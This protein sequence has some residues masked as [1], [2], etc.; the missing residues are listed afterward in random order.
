MA[1]QKITQQLAFKAGGALRSLG[2]LNR[3]LQD[4]NIL[5]KEMQT[6]TGGTAT[7]QFAQN[8]KKTS[9]EI[10]KTKRS[11]AGFTV[12]WETMLR[13]IQTQ[14]I[15]RGL[16]TLMQQLREG[17]DVARQLGINIE[18]IRTIAGGG[19]GG[20]SQI[21]QELIELSNA[22]GKAPTDLAEGLYQTLSNQVVETGE[23]FN[24]M[25]E[26]AKLATVTSSQTG[27]AVNALSSVLNSYNMEASEATHVSGTLFKTVELGR[28]RLGEIANVIGRVTPI[29]ARLGITWEETAASIATMT[30]QGVRA[31]T[32][33]TQLRAVTQKLLKPT[34][35]IKNL[36]KEWGV[37]TGEQAIE[38]FGG[39]VG[40][41]Q[42]MSE[43]TAG[44]SQEMA[45]LFRRVRAIVG[46][47]GIMQDEGSLVAE[48][49][50][51]IEEASNASVK[52]W[53][54][55]SASDAQ[56]YTRTLQEF[57][58]EMT[59]LGRQAIPVITAGLQKINKY[60]KDFAVGWKVVTGSLDAA[61]KIQNTFQKG[62]EELAETIKEID[63][64]FAESQRKQEKQWRETSKAAS[65]Y[66]SYIN[67]QENLASAIRDAGIEQATKVYERSFSGIEDFFSS[68]NKELKK[69]IE[70]AYNTIEG[71]TK[72][73]NDIQ[74]QINQER[75][76]NELSDAESYN[77]KRLILQ[78]ELEA[79]QQRVTATFGEL[80]ADPKTLERAQNEL[81]EVIALTE[82]LE[83]AASASGDTRTVEQARSMRLGALRQQQNVLRQY[84]EEVEKGLGKAKEELKTRKKIAEQSKASMEEIKA[85]IKSGDLTSENEAL[86]ANAEKRLKEAQNTLIEGVADAAAG[87]AILESFNLDYAFSELSSGLEESLN[88]AKKDWDAE[89]DRLQAAFDDKVLKIRAEIDAERVMRDAGSVLG[90]TRISG[91]SEASYLKRV[92]ELAEDTVRTFQDRTNEVD[93]YDARISQLSKNIDSNLAGA[94][95]EALSVLNDEGFTTFGGMRAVA[96]QGALDNKKVV[97]GLS[98]RFKELLGT[99]KN[100]GTVSN[101]ELVKFTG[102]IN[103]LEEQGDIPASFAKNL[104][105]LVVELKRLSKAGEERL[106]ILNPSAEDKEK[107]KAAKIL[108][109][110]R[111]RIADAER[112]TKEQTEST[113]RS[114]DSQKQKAGNVKQELSSAA[115]NAGRV[116][117]QANSSVP[118]INAA[119]QATARWAAQ[120][121]RAAAA[122]GSAQAA[123]AYHGKYFNSGGFARGQDRTLA[124]ISKGEF[125][126]NSKNSKRFFSELNAMNQGSEPV[127]R[128]KG[129]SVTNVGDVN[130]T[131]QGGDT[132]QSTVREIGKSLRR[133]IQRGNIKL[134]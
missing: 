76:D 82:R 113:N 27:D 54:Q 14:I 60:I 89:V 7:N 21:S 85:I 56:E 86:R 111:R 104:R 78:R 53:E 127:Y 62:Q 41:L 50:E 23:A 81:K 10:E 51:Q 29:T 43:S 71:T 79:S 95:K 102:R 25:A 9:K 99:F 103:R 49:L 92:N 87:D 28:L 74:R 72:K 16:S 131:V 98:I 107:L 115:I 2:A 109:D 68:A 55:F 124:A 123:T 35:G 105:T 120:A 112:K 83:K 122:G 106:D 26:A 88:S 110:E 119:A 125:V 100:L 114:L 22:I 40:V 12:T 39:L 129:G 101:E 117:Q 59:V 128:D 18:E 31:D 44:N 13:V 1:P 80:G 17:V 118:G 47:F 30:R 108:L 4:T 96:D 11:T 126:V 5:L 121:E 52:A 66:Y 70:E 48:S 19:L 37:E 134:R 67:R 84:N 65:S 77:Q 91:E 24:F 33:I 58:N 8:L 116:G 132:S 90:A 93:K 15:V 63:Q 94:T 3:K 6:N 75:L 61:V 130:V 97:R 57:K 69:S 20:A 46:Y 133:E 38:K 45:D 42:K 36:Y 34:E 64:E 73:I 32:A